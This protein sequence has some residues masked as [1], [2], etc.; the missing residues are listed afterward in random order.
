MDN[1]WWR[2]ITITVPWHWFEPTMWYQSSGC[3]GHK[4]LWMHHHAF[5][6]GNL[7]RWNTG[8]FQTQRKKTNL[9]KQVLSFRTENNCTHIILRISTH[10]YFS[11]YIYRYIFNYICIIRYM[12]MFSGN[13]SLGVK[14]FYCTHPCAPQ[15][16]LKM[17]MADAYE[18]STNTTAK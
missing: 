11:P 7:H 17:R 3:W 15:P 12:A 10:M 13:K 4:G 2:R 5:S 1:R 16:R 9:G 8:V 18:C 14:G 6:G